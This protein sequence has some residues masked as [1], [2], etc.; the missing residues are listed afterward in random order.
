MIVSRVRLGREIRARRERLRLAPSELGA[1]VGLDAYAVADLERGARP[2]GPDELRRLAV[3][4]GTTELELLRRPSPGELE[5]SR[6]QAPDQVIH[7][8]GSEVVPA[9]VEAALTEHPAVAEAGVVGVPDPFVGFAIKA[10][11]RVRPYP[12]VAAKELVQFCRARMTPQTAPR[13]VEI[14]DQLP[15]DGAG[16]VDRQRLGDLELTRM[17]RGRLPS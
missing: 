1:R 14:L 17:R 8:L 6:P 12:T 4:L 15:H 7:V 9:D 5:P 13:Q 11:V 16:E 2:V 10:F 3:A